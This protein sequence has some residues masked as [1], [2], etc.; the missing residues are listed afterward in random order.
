MKP[1]MKI[2]CKGRALLAAAALVIPLPALAED[3][4]EPIPGIDEDRTLSEQLDENKGV[5]DPPPVGDEEI[6]APA[7]E[8]LPGTTP[9]IPPPGTPGGDLSVEPK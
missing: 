5:I 9:V 6:H 1:A 8:P 4:S 7:P 2:A 3:P